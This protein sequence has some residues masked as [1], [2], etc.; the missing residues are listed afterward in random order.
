M[1]AEV[2]QFSL[3]INWERIVRAFD[4]E[5]LQAPRYTQPTHGR[6]AAAIEGPPAGCV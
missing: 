4:P 2:G 5:A 3:P 6:E 1:S